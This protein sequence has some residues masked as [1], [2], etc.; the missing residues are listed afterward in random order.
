MRLPSRLSSTICGPPFNGVLGC[1]GCAAFLTIP[2]KCTDPVL[3]GWKGSVTS[4]CRNSPVPKQDTYRKRSSSERLMSVIKGGT[5][6][7]PCKRGGKFAG[8]AGSAGISITFLMAHLSFSRYQVQT[9]AERSF[10]EI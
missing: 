8:S 6:L 3:R 7:N 9:E 2:P 4:Y 5:A 1:L 10:R